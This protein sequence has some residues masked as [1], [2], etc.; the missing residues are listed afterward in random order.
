MSRFILVRHGKTK[1]HKASRFWGKTD[2]ELSD[3]GIRQAEQLRDCLAKEKINAVYTSQLSRA[4]RTA[5]I[6]AARQG[7]K[8]QVCSDLNECNFGF[9]EGMTFTEIQKQYPELAE[10]LRSS[11]NAA[12]FAGGESISE[13]DE[14]VQN[15]LPHLKQHKEKETVLIVAHGGTLLLLIC[16]LLE[17]DISN[18][19]KLRLDLASRTIIDT[20][21]NGAIMSKLNDT[22]HLKT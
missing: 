1:L 3:T 17:I 13:L 15:F 19:R 4:R 8:V 18:W 16:H 22:S 6:I 7:V 5:E 11:D 12:K 10:A 20:S 14:R 2:V 9:V 21:D